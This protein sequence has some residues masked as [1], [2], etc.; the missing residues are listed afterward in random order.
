MV[1]PGFTVL[2]PAVLVTFRSAAVAPGSTVM[3]ALLVLL[4][5][6]GSLSAP[7]V[8]VAVLV[9]TAPAQFESTWATTS[10][11]KPAAGTISPA[12][13]V[14][15]CPLRVQVSG[16]LL[17]RLSGVSPAGRTS[18]SDAPLDVAGPLLATVMT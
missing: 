18:V 12:W 10:T 13:Q 1:P 17:D 8:R 6:V 11:W 4:A 15:V 14:T 5:A 16:A 9:M 3:V 7:G 2:A